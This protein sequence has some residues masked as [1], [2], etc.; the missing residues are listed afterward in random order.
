MAAKE[1]MNFC[2]FPAANDAKVQPILK[3][4]G[5]DGRQAC[6]QDWDAG[7]EFLEWDSPWRLSNKDVWELRSNGYTMIELWETTPLVRKVCRIPL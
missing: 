6:L 2:M 4:T 7:K 5:A 3:L 1:V